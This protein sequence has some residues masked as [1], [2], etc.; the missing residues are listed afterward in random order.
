M[1]DYQLRSVINFELTHS[2]GG[3]TDSELDEVWEK[4]LDYYLGRPRGDEKRGRSPLISMDVADMVEQTLAQMMP[5]FKHDDL[6]QFEPLDE[7]D[8]EQAALESDAMNHIVMKK[9]HGYI[10]I[11]SAVKDGMLQRAGILKAYI[12]E[13]IFVT[14]QRY[15]SINVFE[16]EQVLMPR[17]PD[18]EVE[19]TAQRTVEPGMSTYDQAGNPVIISPEVFDIE[20]KRTTIKK[21]LVIESVAPEEIRIN[22]D[23]NSPFIQMARFVS[24]SRPVLRTHLIEWGY[25][26]DEVM[27]LPAYTTDTESEERARTRDHSESEHYSAQR[28]TD[29]V[30][31][32][33]IYMQVDF[34]NDGIAERRQIMGA[35]DRGSVTHVFENTYFP[36]IPMAGGTPFI[37]PHRFYGLSF[38]DKLKQIQDS[39]TRFLRLTDDNAESLINQRKV[40]TAGEVNMDDLLS[41]RP[42]GV[43]RERTPNSVRLEPSQPLGD[44]GFKMM[45]YLDKM[46][47]EHGGSALNL[48]TNEN[49]PVKNAGAH[50][51]ERWM[52][53]KE[54]LTK[55]MTECFAE[56]MVQGIYLVAHWLVRTHLPDQLNFKRKQGWAQ[57][58]PEQWRDREDISLSIGL[59]QTERMQR[60]T[61]LESVLQKQIQALGEGQDGVLTDLGRVHR[62]L[63]DQGRA[64]GLPAPEQYWIDPDSPEAKQAMQAKQQA[65]QETAA[66][67]Q[68]MMGQMQQMTMLIEQMKNEAK[69]NGDR[70]DYA[71]ESNEQLRKWVETE[72]KYNT[73]IE[74]QGQGA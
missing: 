60:V 46:R 11:L 56:T 73:D 34:D 54:L 52:T 28:L 4:G 35:G 5:A 36:I 26:E 21:K 43:I 70:L 3:D 69:V 55:L 50:G 1:N 66:R 32:H 41:S 9:N 64:A 37:M 18:E 8:E 20:V 71:I 74:G 24:H 10:N 49:N 72:L 29:S 14:G 47:E 23:I 67:E 2:L 44:T 17:T 16:L 61:A 15:D 25:P 59:T 30:M 58:N 57:T 13:S 7:Q 65:A 39:K 42:G 63:L 22:S 53:S 31:F 6:A 12:D 51:M 27:Q 48:G 68:Q 33:E 62:T 40:V 38:Y 19:I 45:T